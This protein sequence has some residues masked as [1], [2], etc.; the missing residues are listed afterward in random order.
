GGGGGP[1]GGGGGPPGAPPMYRQAPGA[2]PGA[3]YIC[4]RC[5]KPGHY[6]R[7]CPTNGDPT[8]DNARV[9]RVHGVPKNFLAVVG[10]GN[11]KPF[12]GPAIV[13]FSAFSCCCLLPAWRSKESKGGAAAGAVDRAALSAAA[14]EHLKCP[15]CGL[16]MEDA[17]IARCCHQSA[18][19]KCM[20]DALTDANH[21]RCPMCSR[22]TS[23]DDLAP[24]TSIRRAIEA[25]AAAQTA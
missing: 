12:Q 24:N 18:C 9:K 20:R 11:Q 8:F 6:I 5:N 1:G 2:A 17:V 14:P 19:D 3:S 23:P 7:D 21:L 15:V 16:V 4:N 10:Q 13:N 25:F 22:Q